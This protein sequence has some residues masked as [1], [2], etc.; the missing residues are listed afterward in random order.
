MR[1]YLDI[2]KNWR[3]VLLAVAWIIA[4]LC[5]M[6]DSDDLLNVLIKLV[7]LAIGFYAYKLGERWHNE[8]LIDEINVFNDNH[9]ED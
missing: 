5:I 3:C 6:A 9:N 1:K 4:L 7:G 8:G 2:F